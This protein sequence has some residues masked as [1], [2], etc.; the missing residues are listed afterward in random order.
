MFHE[1]QLFILLLGFVLTDYFIEED[2]GMPKCL[3]LTAED[4]E[5]RREK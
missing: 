4:A 1:H 3:K 5:V 2:V